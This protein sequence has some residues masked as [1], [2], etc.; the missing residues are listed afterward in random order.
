MASESTVEDVTKTVG[1][2][3]AHNKPGESDI[4]GDFVSQDNQ[5]FVLHNSNGF[6]PGDVANFET[7]RDIIQLRPPGELPLK[8]RIHSVWLCTE[9]PTAEGRILEIGDERLLELAHK[10]KILVV[11]MFTQYDRLVRTKKD[12]LEE[13]EE[14]LDQSTLDTRSEDQAHRSFMACVESLHRTMDHLQI[15]MP[16]YVK[17]SGYEEEVSELVKVTRDIVREQ[18]KGDA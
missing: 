18:I 13:E 3:V 17:G 12:E 8:D 15:P 7:V 14:D 10:I 16:H 9:T 6:E 5:F 2:C 11:I 1:S 4:Q